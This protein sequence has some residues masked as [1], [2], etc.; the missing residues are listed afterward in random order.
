M[1]CGKPVIATSSG[2]MPEI[3]QDGEVGYIVP[4]RN[5]RLLAEK[6]ITLVN[7]KDLAAEIGMKARDRVIAEF[8]WGK[9]VSRLG[10]VYERV[11]DDNTVI[12]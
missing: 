4:K 1:S 3:V 8:T 2:G 11:L 7:N 12:S 10:K 9:V 6:I 5:E